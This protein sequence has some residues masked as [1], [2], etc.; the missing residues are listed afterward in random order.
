MRI[1]D[2]K[3]T[4]LKLEKEHGNIDHCNINFRYNNNSDVIRLNFLEEDLFDA[5]NN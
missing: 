1:K 3:K 2:L 4:I 5:G